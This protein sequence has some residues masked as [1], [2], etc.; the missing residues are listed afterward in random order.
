MDSANLYTMLQH[1]SGSYRP[2]LQLLMDL[3]FLCGVGSV[4]WGIHSLR[5]NSH[6]L[7][8]GGTTKGV[9]AAVLIGS[10][11]TT[12]PGLLDMVTYTFFARGAE[13]YAFAY[14]GNTSVSGDRLF[15][16]KG[17][18][19]LFGAYSFIKGWWS[20]RAVAVHG[21]RSNAT[22]KGALVRIIAGAALVNI[23]LLAS[24]LS[25]T[26]GVKSPIRF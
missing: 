21:Q 10:A 3:T 12:V 25:V 13:N 8:N 6:Y 17:L 14:D 22:V 9:A 5:P 19:Q 4:I 1:A 20:F 2:M 15:A 16:V 18:L 7:Q 11:L 23:S 24:A 26:L